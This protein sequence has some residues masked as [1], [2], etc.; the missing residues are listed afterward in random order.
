[1]ALELKQ[2]YFDSPHG[3]SNWNNRSSALDLCK[4]CSICMKIPKF[5][6]VVGTKIFRVTKNDTNKNKR[7]YTWENTQRLLWQKGVNGVKTGVTDTAGPCLATSLSIED[8]EL[9]VVILNSKSMEARWIE[10]MKLAK[11]TI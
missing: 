1:M 9:V 5:R 4:L 8:Y 11:W 3:L 7:S 6:Q 10:T 2:S